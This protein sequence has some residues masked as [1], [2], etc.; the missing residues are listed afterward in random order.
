MFL[1]NSRH[2]FNKMVHRSGGCSKPL[3]IPLGAIA[4]TENFFSHK[5][6]HP[7]PS[8]DKDMIEACSN[9]VQKGTAQ[10]LATLKNALKNAAFN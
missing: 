6:L 3:T 8:Y 7:E 4:A 2:P 5:W 10:L 1:I 9:I